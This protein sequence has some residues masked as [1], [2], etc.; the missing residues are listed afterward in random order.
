MEYDFIKKVLKNSDKNKSEFFHKLKEI[1][2]DELKK[3]ENYVNE[4]KIQLTE[5]LKKALSINTEE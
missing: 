3:N 1:N 5:K 4:M 2:F